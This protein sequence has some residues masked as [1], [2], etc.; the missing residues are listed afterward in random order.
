M[1]KTGCRRAVL[2]GGI[3]VGLVVLALIVALAGLW[4]F[5]RAKQSKYDPVAIPYIE[6]ALPVI[7]R[8]ELDDFREFFVPEVLEGMSEQEM[9]RFFLWF[10]RLGSLQTFEE[11]EFVQI[12]ASTDVPYPSLI[13]YQVSAQYENGEAT[14][15]FVLVPVDSETVKLWL[16]HIDSL[17]L[18]P[19]MEGAETD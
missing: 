9:E 17:A 8:W 13:T 12:S 3:G 1:K 14:V 16:F 19:T 15:T 10:S 7:S 5:V 6:E 4:F 2:I 18:L 11:P